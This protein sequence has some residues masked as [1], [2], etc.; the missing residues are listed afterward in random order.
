DSSNHLKER[1]RILAAAVLFDALLIGTNQLTPFR[2]LARQTLELGANPFGLP[3]FG[4]RFEPPIEGGVLVFGPFLGMF[5]ELFDALQPGVGIF[6]V[7][8]L[9]L[10][11][12]NELFRIAPGFI[13]RDQG[14]RRG[15]R[16][17]VDRQRLFVRAHGLV[18]FVELVA[19]QNRDL[20]G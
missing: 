10:E 16:V 5:G 9:N 12:A 18:G 14:F 7:A 13:Q 11:D 2:G 15:Q 3:V 1:Q 19:I 4:V 8:Q 20:Y 17:F 6:S